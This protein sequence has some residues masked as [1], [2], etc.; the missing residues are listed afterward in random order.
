M[1][2]F[3]KGVSASIRIT[4]I[5]T[6]SMQY[7]R[8]SSPARTMNRSQSRA[9]HFGISPQIVISVGRCA[10]ALFKRADT[11]C[12]QMPSSLLWGTANP[13]G[14]GP[15]YNGVYLTSVDVRNMVQQINE[16]RVAGENIP[17]HIEH[18]GVGVGRVVSAWEHNNTLQ[19][20]LELDESVLEGAIGGEFVRSGIC[21]DLSL[22]YTVDMAHSKN[23]DGKIR[24]Q[25][26]KLKEISI[27][28]KGARKNCHIHGY[29]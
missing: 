23:S 26:K 29:S 22:G 6:Q 17:V 9:C 7:V 5:K 10:K 18:K 14:L 13:E 19:C 15:D 1:L 2:S 21:K 4:V 12:A 27:V 3:D 20:V 8:G 25:N 11:S 16:A 28:K 24:T